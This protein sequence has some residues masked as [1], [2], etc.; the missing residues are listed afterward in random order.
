[1]KGKAPKKVVRV[2]PKFQY[3]SLCCHA[4]TQKPELVKQDDPWPVG[5]GHW[6]CSKCGKPCKTERW[7]KT[8]P[9]PEA[10]NV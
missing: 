9:K 4:P 6:R 7:A 8:V 3:V 2:E 1:M 5:L 10:T